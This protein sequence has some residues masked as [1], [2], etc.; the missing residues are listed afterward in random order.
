MKIRIIS[1]L[2][3]L[4]TMSS[5]VELLVLLKKNKLSVEKCMTFGTLDIDDNLCK[6]LLTKP[7]F[8]FNFIKSP[9]IKEI[10]LNIFFL[11]RKAFSLIAVGEIGLITS[12][13][14]GVILN[15]QYV[16][17]CDEIPIVKSSFYSRFHFLL[18]RRSIKMS[19]FLI[20]QD[21]ARLEFLNDSFRLDLTSNKVM[22]LTNTIAQQNS[23]KVSISFPK[24]VLWSGNLSKIRDNGVLEILKNLVLIPQKSYSLTIIVRNCNDSKLYNELYSL[25]E[26]DP[27]INLLRDLSFTDF[28]NQIELHDIGL[29]LY[30]LNSR[31]PN[32]NVELIGKSSGQLNIYMNRG[33]PCV[34]ENFS[35]FDFLQDSCCFVG[36]TQEVDLAIRCIV[37]DYEKYAL[38]SYEV[39]N[40]ELNNIRQLS[41]IYNRLT[42]KVC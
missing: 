41:D 23:Q 22:L 31:V 30:Y 19:E 38:R 29:V 39:Y 24:K 26:V 2:P 9:H 27:S 37:N 18:L 35:S 34:V 14:I 20:I 40:A 17:F 12:Y 1:S 36:T 10:V 32:K 11:P 21:N 6:F 8:P 3:Y 7:I 13:F 33:L 42:S 28:I 16:Y 25:V 5:F 4:G 15:K